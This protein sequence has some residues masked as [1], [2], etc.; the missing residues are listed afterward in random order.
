MIQT[1]F[2]LSEKNKK[3]QSYKK[4]KHRP[5]ISNPLA[6]RQQNLIEFNKN[7]NDCF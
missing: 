1:Y 3:S 4:T 7:R 2:I 6:I 5:E